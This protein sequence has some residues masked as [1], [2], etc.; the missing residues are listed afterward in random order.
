MKAFKRKSIRLKNFDYRD[1]Y[2]YFITICTNENKSYFKNTEFAIFIVN[3]IDYRIM[4]GEV[5][6]YC[7]CIKP[8]HIHILLSLNENYKK[9]LSVWISSFKRYI[10]KIAKEKFNIPHVWQKNYYDHV[11][12]TDESL[13]KIAEYILNNPVRRGLVNKWTEYPFSRLID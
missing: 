9:S 5:T 1:G 2:A 13:T 12:R 6:M 8:N 11:V 4:L 3:T 10:T 7:Y